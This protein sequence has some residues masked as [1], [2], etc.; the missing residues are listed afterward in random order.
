MAP[1]IAS[2][3]S[4]EL[5]TRVHTRATVCFS[6]SQVQPHHAARLRRLCELYE[7]LPVANGRVADVA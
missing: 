3:S 7:R 5:S 4:F 2:A 1:R 6:W